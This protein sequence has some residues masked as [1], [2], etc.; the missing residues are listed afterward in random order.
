MQIIFDKAGKRMNNFHILSVTE[1]QV[2]D[3]AVFEVDEKNARDYIKAKK[4][5]E[6]K[7]PVKPEP[8]K[9]TGDGEELGTDIDKMTVPQLE[10]FAASVEPVI[11]ISEAKNKAEKLEIISTEI[12]V[13]KA[14]LEELNKDN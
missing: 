10:E 3:G 8:P 2:E 9:D 6:Y 12:A 5:H 13:R 7:E 1:S 11:D 4:A 14:A